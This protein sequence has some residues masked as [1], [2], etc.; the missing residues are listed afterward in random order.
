ME[1]PSREFL[2]GLLPTNFAVKAS[3]K[4]V[5]E[6]SYSTD[7]GVKLNAALKKGPLKATMDI[8]GKVKF[9]GNLGSFSLH[10]DPTLKGLGAKFKSLSVVYSL[11]EN[12]DIKYKVTFAALNAAS[13][14]FGG[15]FDLEKMVL[16]RGLLRGAYRPLKNR[17]QQLK[18]ALDS[19]KQ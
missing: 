10:G 17:E 16:D 2:H 11:A 4:K 13:I 3:I 19:A 5:L 14:S 9:S 15:Q 1:I 18:D 6:V 12:G 8:N 7:K